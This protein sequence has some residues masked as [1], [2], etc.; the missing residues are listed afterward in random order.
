MLG[1]VD[2]FDAMTSDRP[3]RKALGHSEAIAEL[4]RCAGSQFDPELVDSFIA[5]VNNKGNVLG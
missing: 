4:M 5:L 1:I 3:Y 2:A